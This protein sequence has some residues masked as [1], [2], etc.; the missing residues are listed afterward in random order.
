V[1]AAGSRSNPAVACASPDQFALHAGEAFGEIALLDGQPHSADAIAVTDCEL[2]VI[3]RRDFFRFV[4]GEPKVAVKLIEFLCARLRVASAREE[5]VVF[6][7]LPARLARLL[8]RLLEENAAGADK[9]KLSTQHEISEI[10]GTTR[11]SVNKH[12]QTWAKRK[13]IALRRGTILV[14][15]PRALAALVSAD[16]DGDDFR[17]LSARPRGA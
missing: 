6:L 10:L 2:M 8:L 7:N 13:V 12:L 11:E 3:E 16:D 15:A 17:P 14:L 9:N 5:V 1:N 4:H